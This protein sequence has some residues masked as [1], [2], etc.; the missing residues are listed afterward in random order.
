MCVLFGIYVT[1]NRGKPFSS[2]EQCR[3][4]TILLRSNLINK[5]IILLV[6]TRFLIG[7]V[8]YLYLEEL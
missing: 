2:G 8:K 3:Q 5:K 7:F 1:V 4:P 6:I